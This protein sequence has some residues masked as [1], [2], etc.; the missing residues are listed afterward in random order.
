[1]DTIV[2]EL[3]GYTYLHLTCRSNHRQGETCPNFSEGITSADPMK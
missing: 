3:V 2:T 1:M